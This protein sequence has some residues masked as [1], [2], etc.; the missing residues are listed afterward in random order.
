MWPQDYPDVGHNF[1]KIENYFTRNP[2]RCCIW[3]RD[4][5]TGGRVAQFGQYSSRRER[6]RE[7]VVG[8][9][10]RST[11]HR[12]SMDLELSRRGCFGRH[13]GSR[14]GCDRCEQDCHVHQRGWQHCL[15]GLRNERKR[16]QQWRRG[17]R[18][19]SDRSG[20]ARYLRG[21]SNHGYRCGRGDWHGDSRDR[22][23][24]HGYDRSTTTADR[25]LSHVLTG[26]RDRARNVGV[27]RD[28]QFRGFDGWFERDAFEQ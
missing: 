23:W 14:C 24:R 6:Q 1:F 17:K 9:E 28:A 27:H 20:N 21:H 3:A 8:D 11:A 16:D 4:R 12:P 13:G 22:K 7:P 18:H 10:R 5:A 26:E 25:R 19:H 15:P 2:F